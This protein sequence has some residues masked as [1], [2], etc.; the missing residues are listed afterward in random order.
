MLRC[1]A[2]SNPTSTSSS[3]TPSSPKDSGRPPSTAAPPSTPTPS[4]NSPATP[5]SSPWCS[6]PK[7]FHSTWDANTDWS[8]KT[9][10]PHSSHATEDVPSPDVIYP[11]DG[12]THTIFI[13]GWTAAKPTSR[14]WF[15]SAADI[16]A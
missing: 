16:T 10:A 14:T 6:T 9:N 12:Q 2:G 7:V 4:A 1:T 5:T 13:T 3:T 8:P 11:P 15:Y